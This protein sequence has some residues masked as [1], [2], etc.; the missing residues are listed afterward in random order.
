M[1]TRTMSRRTFFGDAAQVSLVGAVLFSTGC[2][3]Q[4]C[5]DP[6]IL[7]RGEQSLR[8][9]VNYTE[10]S[11]HHDQNCNGCAMFQPA[12]AEQCGSCQFLSGPVNPEGH[13]DSWSKSG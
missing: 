10:L 1:K 2:S 12:D 7:S 13:C 3:R 6:D 11:P 5:S 8:R 4:L 9:S